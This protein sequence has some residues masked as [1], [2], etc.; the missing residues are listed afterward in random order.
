MI[1]WLFLF[2]RTVCAENTSKNCTKGKSVLMINT[3]SAVKITRE[4]TQSL[5]KN[6]ANTHAR[7]R[8]GETMKKCFVIEQAKGQSEINC[9]SSCIQTKWASLLWNNRSIVFICLL[10]YAYLQQRKLS[11]NIKR[12][13]L[14]LYIFRSPNE[15]SVHTSYKDFLWTYELST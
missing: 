3:V 13:K 8:V 10:H 11:P 2:H 6:C 7:A 14:R 4:S 1:G 5:N 9:D 12:N 15:K